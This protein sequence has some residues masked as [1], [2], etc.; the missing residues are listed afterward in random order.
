MENASLQ[1]FS[2]LYLKAPPFGQEDQFLQ[3]I[4]SN[5]GTFHI[6]KVLPPIEEFYISACTSIF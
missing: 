3:I 4:S 2:P 1:G 5:E 6:H